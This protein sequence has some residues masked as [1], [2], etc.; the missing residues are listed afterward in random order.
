MRRHIGYGFVM[1]L[2]LLVIVLLTVPA[3]SYAQDP[4]PSVEAEFVAS[5]IFRS[6]SLVARAWKEIHF[7]G[8]YLGTESANAGITAL[9]WEFRWKHFSILPGFGVA[10]GSGVQTVPAL[11]FRWKFET[12]RWF[13]QGYFAQSLLAQVAESEGE[14]ESE[15]AGHT[16]HASVLDNNHISVKLGP[17]EIGGLWEHIKYREENEWKGG[18]RGA[19]RLGEHFKLIV[20]S[21]WPGWEMRGGLAFEK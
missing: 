2:S 17:T 6:G 5:G 11:T 15:S 12:R 20:Q 14:S 4:D 19:L 3:L 8:Q 10:F 9:A 1:K 18:V 16:V 13:S 21:V 7:Y